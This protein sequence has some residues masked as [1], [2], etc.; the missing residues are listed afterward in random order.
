MHGPAPPIIP[1]DMLLLAYR[2]GLFPMADSREDTEVFWVEPDERAIIPLDTFQPG[3]SLRKIVRQDRFRVTIDTAFADVV[4]ACAAPR[5]DH[6]ESWISDRIAA[7]YGALH[8]AGYAHSVECWLEQDGEDRLAGGLYGVAFD[9]TFCGESMFSRADNASKVALV[10][11]VAMLKRADFRVLDC[12]FM[13]GHLA[14]LGAVA[15]SQAQYLEKLVE[16]RDHATNPMVT[17]TLG[18]AYASFVSEASAPSSSASSPS[19]ALPALSSSSPGK[20]IAQSFIQT[21]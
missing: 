2:S 12:Q 10:W 8:E 16:A 4:A 7:S 3:R 6:P 9:R 21:S 19:S 1:S 15:L 18:D 13:T 17:M 20:V 11:L 5:P 14:S